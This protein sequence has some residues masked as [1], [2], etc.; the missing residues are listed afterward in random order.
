M[1]EKLASLVS[2]KNGFSVTH[3]ISILKETSEVFVPFIF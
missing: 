2:H 1:G 3:L